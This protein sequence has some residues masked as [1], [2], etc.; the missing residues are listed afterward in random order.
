M[1]P[2]SENNPPSHGNLT[3]PGQQRA[4]TRSLANGPPA[5]PPLTGRRESK[6]AGVT[7][8]A[9]A[10]KS[11]EGTNHRADHSATPAYNEGR[12]PGLA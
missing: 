8:P 1:P 4:L 7:T 5:V 9:A 11:H 2:T 10:T 3:I 12:Q 6:R